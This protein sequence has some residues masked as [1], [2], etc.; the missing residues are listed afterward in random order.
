MKITTNLVEIFPVFILNLLQYIENQIFIS[1]DWIQVGQPKKKEAAPIL[2]RLL[3]TRRDPS[4][5]LEWGEEGIKK[6]RLLL[7]QPLRLLYF[8]L[9]FAK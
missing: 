9:G 5:L 3:Y 1:L 7:E 6:Q 8:M 2:G 4:S